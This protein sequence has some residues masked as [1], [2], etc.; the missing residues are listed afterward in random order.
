M[1]RSN[2]AKIHAGGQSVTP[3]QKQ[4]PADWENLA[5]QRAPKPLSQK[6][7]SWKTNNKK[8]NIKGWIEIQVW[9]IFR[10]SQLFFCRPK[11]LTVSRK[12]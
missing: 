6:A 4:C 11:N 5:Y 2:G 7:L 12:S 3:E 10:H 9:Q 1:S 8:T